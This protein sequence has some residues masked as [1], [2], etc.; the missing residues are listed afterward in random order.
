[1]LCSSHSNVVNFLHVPCLFYNHSLL[2]ESL[3]FCITSV[4]SRFTTSAFFLLNLITGWPWAES[5]S[6]A[7]VLF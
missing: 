1:M 6:Q 7:A 4:N 2:L 3:I 5:S